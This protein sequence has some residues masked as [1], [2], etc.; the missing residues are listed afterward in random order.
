[1]LGGLQLRPDAARWLQERM[2]TAAAG[3]LLAHLLGPRQRPENDSAA[4]WEDSAALRA[5]EQVASLLQHGKRFSM[6]IHGAALLYN[7]L[8]AQRYESAG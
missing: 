6:E 4:P 8:V 3:T 2:L 5:P 1:V 7:L